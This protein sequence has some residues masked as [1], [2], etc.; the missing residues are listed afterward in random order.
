MQEEGW[1]VIADP[2]TAIAIY[3]LL[4]YKQGKLTKV[5]DSLTNNCK[6]VKFIGKLNSLFVNNWGDTDAPLVSIS[7]KEEKYQA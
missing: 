2:N 4:L 7:L 6:T 1:S 5:F 3:D